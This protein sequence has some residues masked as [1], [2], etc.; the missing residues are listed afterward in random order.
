MDEEKY[1]LSDWERH[2]ILP[3]SKEKG[4]PKFV[5]DV[6]YNLRRFLVK[7]IIDSITEKL[8]PNNQ[9]FDSKISN[10]DLLTEVND[11]NGLQIILADKLNRVV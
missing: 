10:K 2:N 6:I 8:N 4:L 7:K 9:D 3:K 11:Y 5:P 1:V